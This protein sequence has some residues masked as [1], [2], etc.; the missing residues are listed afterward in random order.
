MGPSFTGK[1]FGAERFNLRLLYRRVHG[2][3]GC[4]VRVTEIWAMVC[5]SQK[6]ST[7]LRHKQI[8]EKDGGIRNREVFVTQ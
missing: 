5:R 3:G 8:G 6:P 1:A 2:A 4:W 7:G